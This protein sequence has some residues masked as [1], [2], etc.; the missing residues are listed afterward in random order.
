[1]AE[2]IL[3]YDELGQVI[4]LGT[5]YAM[6]Y[7]ARDDLSSIIT[8]IGK[9]EGL[10]HI[11]IY[12]KDGF[13][14]FSNNPSEV[15]QKIDINSDACNV[16]HLSS[17]PLT[18]QE[19]SNRKRVFISDEGVRLMGIVSP[20]YNEPGCSNGVC[21]AH[22]EEK[23]ILG[24]LDIVVSL[25]EMDAELVSFK[26]S[27]GYL[28]LSVFLV[29]TGLIVF[30]LAQFVTVP[31]KKL[32]SKTR[33]I[34]MGEYDALKNISERKDEIGF[35]AKAIHR[36]GMEI[37][38]KQ[39]AL[40]RQKDEYQLLFELI[41]C[42]IT[43]QDRNYRLMGYNQEFSKRFDPEPGDFCFSAYKGRTKKCENCPVEKTFQDGKPHFSEEKGVNKDGTIFHWLVKTAPMKNDRG[44]IIGAVEM[45]LDITHTKLLE[46][47]LRR[48]EKQYT[49]IFNN[50][51]NPV[52]VLDPETLEILDC[53]DS[54]SI[55][56]GYNK[57][58]LLKKSFLMLF[59]EEEQATYIKKIKDL[60][61]INQAHN[62]DKD[63]DIRYINIRISPFEY[64]DRKVLIVTAGDVTKRLET[65]M[66]LIQAGKMATL[67]EMATGVAH[68]LNQPLTVIKAA[69]NY[70][71]K[72]FRNNEPL[73]MDIML[74]MAGEIN[75]HVDRAANIINHMRQ[76]GRKFDLELE[77]VQVNDIL[78]Q[79]FEIFR[80]QLK[81]R[82]ITVEWD[83]EK[84]LP[85][86]LAEAT[87]LEQVFINLLINARDAI[88]EKWQYAGELPGEQKKILISSGLHLSD[89]VIKIHDSGM[90][91]PK[92]ILNKIFEPF[93]TTK[94]VGS[95][96]GIGLSISYG[97]I[98]DF[99][100]SILVSSVK[101]EGTCFT[102]TLPVR[103]I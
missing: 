82:E 95:G 103:N 43:V 83:L 18:V 32:I 29:T 62:I 90:G 52:F 3:N 48:S 93:F 91:I 4:K 30:I 23:K 54:V 53:N 86:V 37:G 94:K 6:M 59:I 101:N 31:I 80:Q 10:E 27:L 5:H 56:Y 66:Q 77:N 28:A 46:D 24:T 20:I 70:F 19:A 12:S 85:C 25:K 33:L 88:D 8:N 41:P 22:T 11:R 35:L 97:I 36:T 84:D 1:M 81:L 44:E 74:D 58:E 40:N 69:A 72:K 96:T 79:A 92:S 45:N 42:I 39:H 7:N 67:G 89:V 98:Q 15:G 87:R 100:G 99:K 64:P 16:C 26:K 50:I 38:K 2:L 61:E 78:K 21:H 65:E 34:A 47:K 102:I 14:K 55:V 9:H 60:A 73:N 57:D 63:G 68:E 51:P 13:I 75:S 76:F 17:P 71:L 49:A